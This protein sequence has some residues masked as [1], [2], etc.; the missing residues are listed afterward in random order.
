MQGIA[1][2]SRKKHTTG[3]KA[4]RAL[5]HLVPSQGRD[6]S[7]LGMGVTQFCTPLPWPQACHSHTT[8]PCPP[9]ACPL[10]QPHKTV[11]WP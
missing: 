8:T 6:A 10:R 4:K 3:V 2:I 7:I 1:A 5:E 11:L 9:L